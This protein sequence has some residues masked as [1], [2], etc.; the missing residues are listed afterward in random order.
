M[1]SSTS[2]LE[3]V[4]EMYLFI[5]KFIMYTKVIPALDCEWYCHSMWNCMHMHRYS[6]WISCINLMG[7]TIESKLQFSYSWILGIR[8]PPLITWHV[9]LTGKDSCIQFTKVHCH[10]DKR[11]QWQ[12]AE[13][14]ND[15]NKTIH[16]TYNILFIQYN[17]L[18]YKNIIDTYSHKHLYGWKFTIIIMVLMIIM[19]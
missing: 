3:A 15:N 16:N 4:P 19:M 11:R 12:M 10:R 2:Q 6:H 1:T 9:Q 14:S 17:E 18:L 7:F 5:Y 8:N 13:I